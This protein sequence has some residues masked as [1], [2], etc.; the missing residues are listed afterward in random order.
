MK[1]AKL[2]LAI[3]AAA[4]ILFVV[5]CSSDKPA[6]QPVAAPAPAPAPE[7]PQPAKTYNTK[8][9]TASTQKDNMK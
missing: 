3:L 5:G 9:G 4:G 8:L 6:P 7:Q 2:G 1:I